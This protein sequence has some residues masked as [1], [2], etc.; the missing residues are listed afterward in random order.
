MEGA[1]D[2]IPANQRA[3]APNGFLGSRILVRELA[4]FVIC[5]D[6]AVAVNMQMVSRQCTTRLL[7]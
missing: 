4:A 6:F 5:D 1:A 3:N 7:A 2:H